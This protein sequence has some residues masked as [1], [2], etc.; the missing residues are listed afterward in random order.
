MQTDVNEDI[1]ER[2][3][4]WCNICDN[5]S[6]VRAWSWDSSAQGF[7]TINMVFV[8][9]A[10][11]HIIE[12]K[13]GTKAI[14][15][16]SLF[17]LSI[18]I[19]GFLASLLM[20]L[21]GAII[22]HTVYRRHVAIC[23]AILILVVNG[24]LAM[25]SEETWKI[26][27]FLI[28]LNG[29]LNLI[30]ITAVYAYL[31]ELTDNDKLRSKYMGTFLA[32][33]S[34]AMLL[35]F[36]LISLIVAFVPYPGLGKTKSEIE[37]KV[38]R[39]AQACVVVFSAISFF[40]AFKNGL[41]NRPAVS[42][43]PK[44]SSLLIIGYKTLYST[45]KEIFQTKAVKWFLLSTLSFGSMLSAIGAILLAYSI[46]FLRMDA[47]QASYSF[48]LITLSL[49]IGSVIYCFCVSKYDPDPLVSLKISVSLL[50]ILLV[51]TGFI[52]KGPE[53][54]IFYYILCALM[55][56]VIGWINPNGRALYVAIIPRGQEA[57]LMG[58]YI[59]FVNAFVWLPSLGV[60]ILIQYGISWRIAI[61]TLSVYSFISVIFLFLMESYSL[62]KKDVEIMKSLRSER[63]SLVEQ[64]RRGNQSN[65]DTMQMEKKTDEESVVQKGI[66]N[67]SASEYVNE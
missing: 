37:I 32:I 51:I 59:F 33:R 56:V 19:A 17:T 36:L 45:C 29:F 40:L 23:S 30:H 50:S 48:M 52:V 49:V 46:H 38:A 24:L 2:R 35:Y 66:S 65:P 1:N 13:A 14:V 60:T 15:P 7:L 28:G 61:G 9:T 8:S 62:A 4:K 39:I 21:A 11:L 64:G 5:N 53:D 22:D 43:V 42:Q 10:L 58:I 3:N 26:C 16:E 20:P 67:G 12:R 27:L 57:E 47:T 41:G 54:H 31:Q 6:D 25:V 55:G 44:G 34:I 18:S 63:T